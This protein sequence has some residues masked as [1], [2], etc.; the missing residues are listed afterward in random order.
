MHATYGFLRLRKQDGEFVEDVE[1]MLLQIPLEL[2]RHGRDAIVIPIAFRVKHSVSYGGRWLR[3][4][5]EVGCRNVGLGADRQQ[6]FHVDA[7][8]IVHHLLE[9]FVGL[10]MRSRL[11][12]DHGVFCAVHVSNGCR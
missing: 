6:R 12:K 10:I 9:P 1:S 7:D 5:H 4:Y 8:R 3:D 2:T 11:Y